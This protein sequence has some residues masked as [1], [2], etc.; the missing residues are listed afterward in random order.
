MLRQKKKLNEGQLHHHGLQKSA[1]EINPAS[2]ITWL[3][4]I[5][6]SCL[7]WLKFK[8]LHHFGC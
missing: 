8:Q 6:Y 3:Q 2:W 5:N 1:A 4:S 7:V